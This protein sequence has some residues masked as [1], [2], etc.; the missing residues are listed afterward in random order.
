MSVH[1]WK[2]PS[3]DKISANTLNQTDNDQ[4]LPLRSCTAIS[5]PRNLDLNRLF[6]CEVRRILCLGTEMCRQN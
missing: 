5:D 1:E 3:T 2:L 6:K 4:T